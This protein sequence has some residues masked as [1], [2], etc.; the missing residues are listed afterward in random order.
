MPTPTPTPTPPN[1]TPPDP[2]RPATPH[3][4]HPAHP[5][6]PKLDALILRAK[7]NDRTALRELIEAVGPRVRARIDPKISH[8]VR[9]LIDTDDVMQVTYMEVVLRLASFT[10]GG[11]SGF[12]AWVSRLAENNL[13]DAVRALEAAKRFD[14]R[15]KV[16]P[17][18]EESASAFINLLGV[19]SLTPSRVAAKDEASSLLE[20][21]LRALPP[22][23]EKV[24]REHDLEGKPMAEIAASMKRSE[25]AGYMLRAR[26]HDRL[27]EI[28]G[29]D[30]KY[31]ST[32][33]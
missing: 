27:K 12:V 11:F 32:P 13:I 10:G 6:D 24:V 28:L 5:A 2:E 9:T 14:P 20:V 15:R 33:G 29:S 16:T 3:P 17:S 7:A 18:R 26:A 1:P 30:S 4:A 21:A 31:F 25:G 19:N 22:D 23:Y 8:A